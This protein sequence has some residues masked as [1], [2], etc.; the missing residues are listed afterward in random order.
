VARL[1]ALIETD[2]KKIVALSTLSQ[3][4]LIFIALALGIPIIC[5]FHIL[6]HALAKANLFIVVGRI[7][8]TRFSQQDSRIISSRTVGP[9]IVVSITVRLLR[10]VG[11]VFIA[12]FFS[13]EQILIG[14]AFLLNRTIS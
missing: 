11:F 12:G 1:S 7:L 9:F 4:G 13:K 5:Y 2:A 3:L 14:Q 8:H 10:L 6:I